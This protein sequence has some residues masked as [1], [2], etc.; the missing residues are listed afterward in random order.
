MQRTCQ[1]PAGQFVFL[2][3]LQRHSS[4]RSRRRLVAAGDAI[5]GLVTSY[6]LLFLSLGHIYAR[7]SMTSFDQLD[8]IN[9]KTGINQT[10]SGLRGRASSVERVNRPNGRSALLVR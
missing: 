3:R 6:C 2:T 1:M 5:Q 7:S 9:L 10:L 4:S 8:L